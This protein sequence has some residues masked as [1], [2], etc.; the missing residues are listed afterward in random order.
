VITVVGLFVLAALLATL[1]GLIGDEVRGWLEL[2]PRAV[3]RLVAM[4]LPADQRA[5]IYNEEWLPELLT[6]MRKAE[7]RPITRLCFG[8]KYAADMVRAAGK[9]GRE[10][11]GVRDK[12]RAAGYEEA[13]QDSYGPASTTGG[14]TVTD[15]GIE[16]TSAG[17]TFTGITFSGTGHISAAGPSG[18]EPESG[19]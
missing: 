13:Y 8:I 17:F 15:K 5:A 10:L 12:D 19:T 14:L 18:Q 1:S 2:V 9:V 16:V 11:D 3:L 4:R 7:G 6:D